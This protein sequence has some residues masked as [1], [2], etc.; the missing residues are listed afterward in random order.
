MIYKIVQGNSFKLHVLVRKPD[1]SSDSSKLIDF[2]MTKATDITVALTCDFGES[3]TIPSHVSMVLPNVV[4]CEVPSTLEI[5][6][7]NV[8]VSWKMDGNDMASVE[9]NLFR[10]VEYNSQVRCPICMVDGDTCKETE[11]ATAIVVLPPT[12]ELWQLVNLTSA[13]IEEAEELSRKMA[14]AEE[15]RASNES[16]RVTAEKERERKTSEALQGLSDA[17]GG[18]LE[19]IE[20]VQKSNED[21]GVNII[22]ATLMNGEKKDFLILNGSKGSPGEKGEKGDKGADGGF[23]DLGDIKV[24]VDATV[25]T[26]SASV[27]NVLGSDGKAQ[28][29]FKF[30]GIKGEKGEDGK[31]GKDGTN[32]TD[33]AKGDKGD[34]FTFADFTKEQLASLKGEKG[35]KGDM[36]S[37][38]K[39]GVSVDSEVGTPS[40]TATVSKNTDGSTNIDFSF[41]GLKGEKGDKGE[42]G[43]GTNVTQKVSK[44]RTRIV[45]RKAIRLGATKANGNLVKYFSYAPTLRLK[46]VSTYL[47]YL[48]GQVVDVSNYL[49]YNGAK[50][51][52]L[53]IQREDLEIGADNSFQVAN[54]YSH[55]YF[56]VPLD[57]GYNSDPSLYWIDKTVTKD[58]GVVEVYVVSRLLKRP[59]SVNTEN[60]YYT[61]SENHVI[62]KLR[63]IKDFERYID[64]TNNKVE[65]T[66]YSIFGDTVITRV[67][68]RVNLRYLKDNISQGQTRSLHI[69]KYKYT[70]NVKGKL[71]KRKGSWIILVKKKGVV[72]GEI[73][74]IFQKTLNKVVF[75]RA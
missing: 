61:I 57:F 16:A 46:A 51:R 44:A 59:I 8:S 34:A 67:K 33:G 23:A 27:S 31:N 5:G 18:N 43:T 14:D 50:Y 30:S 6:N 71:G 48:N 3:M 15:E 60:D 21:G 54:T 2:D 41:T 47:I 75:E 9:R 45:C 12:I 64:H 4:V 68:K 69:R 19:S 39:V 63:H 32:G 40:A 25:G 73:R 17:Q 24:S 1:I 29:T 38:S 52:L 11:V 65:P 13:T 49:T 22:Q 26:P 10:I 36:G 62:G 74:G 70:R 37:I 56:T 55:K 42:D 66:S 35:D 53:V 7:Y 20:Q 28:L 58:N 72:I